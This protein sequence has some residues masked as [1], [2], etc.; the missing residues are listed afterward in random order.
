MARSSP[1][2]PPGGRTG[3]GWAC[4]ATISPRARAAIGSAASGRLP[5][6]RTSTGCWNRGDGTR[7]PT[8]GGARLDLS[9]VRAVV[10]AHHGESTVT[11]NPDGHGRLVVALP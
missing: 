6:P 9:I 8:D 10:T 1:P 5:R 11:A 7:T 3:P 4:P 2:F